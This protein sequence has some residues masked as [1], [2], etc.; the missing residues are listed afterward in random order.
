MLVLV[1]SVYLTLQAKV[2]PY[3]RPLFNVME[4][5]A[6]ST[7]FVVELANILRNASSDDYD[8]VELPVYIMLVLCVGCF[9]YGMVSAFL[10]G[11][12]YTAILQ[13]HVVHHC[14]ASQSSSFIRWVWIRP[15]KAM[16]RKKQRLNAKHE[17]VSMWC[18]RHARYFDIQNWP[19]SQAPRLKSSVV[20]AEAPVKTFQGG[21]PSS[22][23]SSQRPHTAAQRVDMRTMRLR[24]HYSS[25]K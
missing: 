23:S 4:L 5:F 3:D 6:L 24:I 19:W 11:Y 7:T 8:W 17:H 22:N 9:L 2:A 15:I 20:V 1:L 10:H 12:R 14:V 13:H 18:W 25:K 21:N 16:I